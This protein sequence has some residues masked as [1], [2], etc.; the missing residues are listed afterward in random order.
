MMRCEGEGK[1][2]TTYTHGQ[3]KAPAR[4]RELPGRTGEFVEAGEDHYRNEEAPEDHL[5]D[6]EGWSSVHGAGSHY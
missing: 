2:H 3:R 4:R 5:R 6:Q 1:V